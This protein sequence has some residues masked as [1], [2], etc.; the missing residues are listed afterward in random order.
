MN[1]VRPNRTAR[2]TAGVLLI[3]FAAWCYQQYI[4]FSTAQSA[5]LAS[6]PRLQIRDFK[7]IYARALLARNTVPA[8]LGPDLPKPEDPLCIIDV[9]PRALYTQG[10]I[11]GAISIPENELEASTTSVVPRS[12]GDALIVLYCA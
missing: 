9:R 1:A 8:N 12:C 2:V 4:A 6:V 10:H 3:L 5:D 7:L 11:R